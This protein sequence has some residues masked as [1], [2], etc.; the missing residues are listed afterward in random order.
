MDGRIVITQDD[1][2]GMEVDAIVNAANKSLMGGG[3]VDGA[4][5]R[6]AGPELKEECRTMRGCETGQAK[7]TS[8]YR[9][10]ADHVIHTVGPVWHGGDREEERLLSDCYA[11]SLRLAV[12]NGLESIA[13]PSISTGAYGFPISK[14]APIALETVKEHL[15]KETTLRI[16]IFVNFSQGDLE[17][18]LETAAK[19]F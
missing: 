19:M 5:H 17:V 2:T 1:I 14:A 12:E 16:V 10:K 11:N 3:G 8:G 18:Y 9:L 6:A 15:E 13:F 4:I 7:I